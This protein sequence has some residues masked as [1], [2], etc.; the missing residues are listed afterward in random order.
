LIFIGQ[1]NSFP[2]HPDLAKPDLLL[3]EKHYAKSDLL[4]PEKRYAK[5]DLLLPEKH[6]AKTQF[7]AE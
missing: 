1:R 6:Y 4:L 2:A 5:P 3:P 7:S